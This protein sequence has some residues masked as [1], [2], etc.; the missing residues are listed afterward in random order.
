MAPITPNPVPLAPPPMAPALQDS[1]GMT[2]ENNGNSVQ[3]K[4][5]RKDAML[6]TFTRRSFQDAVFVF[7]PLL[8]FIIVDNDDDVDNDGNNADDDGPALFG[9]TAV[10]SRRRLCLLEIMMF[11]LDVDVN[12]AL[13]D[14][15]RVSKMASFSDLVSVITISC[16]DE[17][18]ASSMNV[19]D[20]EAVLM[21]IIVPA[22][23][24]VIIVVLS[25]LKKSSSTFINSCWG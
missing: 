12:N 18:D 20:S 13:V 25:S 16:N 17:D 4:M 8:P 3:S 9:V 24:F 5:H 21:V 14:G 11:D 19:A 15:R 2:T 10:L 22:S 6:D 1:A 7:S 23:S